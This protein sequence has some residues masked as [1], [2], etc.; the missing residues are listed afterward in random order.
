MKSF[1][2]KEK[3]SD[4]QTTICEYLALRGYFFWRSNNVPAF[5]VKRAVFRAFPKFA[6]KGLPDIQIVSKGGFCTF[7]EVKRKGGYQSPEQK[8]F[9]KKCEKVGA[10]YFVV[11]SVDEVIKLG[12]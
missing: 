10:R 12:L 4:I 2:V 8:E 5:D 7:L 9:Q 3:E 11:R 1:P 6:I